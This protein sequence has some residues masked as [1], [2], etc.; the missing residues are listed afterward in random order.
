MTRV[1]ASAKNLI[2]QHGLDPTRSRAPGSRA[3]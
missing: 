3:P 1:Y 2:A